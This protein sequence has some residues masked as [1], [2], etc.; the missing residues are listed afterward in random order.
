M[1]MW[2]FNEII[3]GN[4]STNQPCSKHKITAGYL[5]Q[6]LFFFH[7]MKRIGWTWRKRPSEEPGRQEKVTQRGRLYCFQNSPQRSKE[8]KTF[9]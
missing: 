3:P 6:I 9:L 7:R 2:K 1:E 4:N 8:T 5:L